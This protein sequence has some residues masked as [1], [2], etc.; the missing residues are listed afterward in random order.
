[1]SSP[2]LTLAVLTALYALNYMDRQ[3]MAGVAETMKRDLALTDA[4]VGGLATLFLLCVAGFALPAAVM[5]DRSGKK[6][7]IALMALVW[8]V[9]TAL[10]GT[11]SAFPPLAATRAAVGVG[12]AGFSSGG[13]AIIG[14]S[15][16]TASRGR[17]LGIFNMAVPLG[18]ALGT[19]LSG[20]I[21]AKT[22]SWRTP[23]FIFAVPGLILA[24]VLPLLGKEPPPAP[25]QPVGKALGRLLR[26]PSLRLT[27]LAFAMNVFVSSA[28]L[29]WLP[30]Y[31]TRVYGL[32]AASAGKRAGLILLCA[33]IGAPLGGFL[34]DRLLRVTPRGRPL[35][36]ALT[37]VVAAVCLT[38]GLMTGPSSL[39][40]AGFVGY[41]VF[42]VAYLAPGS[43]IT[44]D[45]SPLELRATAWGACVLSMYLLGGAYSPAIVGKLSDA[46]SGDVAKAMLVAPAAGL[47]S[48]A[49]FVLASRTYAADRAAI[50][51][52]LNT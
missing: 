9:A 33:L 34:G 41:G 8:S 10:T 15:F 21:V 39:S 37:S 50:D 17:V 6:R 49:L 14:A 28:V 44:Q 45:V 18:A 36:C 1:M 23:F 30:A 35:S 12:E 51:A 13:T 7:G 16:P 11:V 26:V 42:T 47:L 25:A 22:G 43:A 24:L 27:Y 38:V 32:D 4:Q 2:R 48:A 40:I 20:L 31:F 46:L 5:L 29:Q 3:V 19:I 52:E